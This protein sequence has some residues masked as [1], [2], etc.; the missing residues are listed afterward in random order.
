MPSI[1]KK[2]KNYEITI[3]NGYDSSGRKITVS[4]TFTPKDT[5]NEER[6]K[7]EVEKFAIRLEEKV[8]N[9][10]NVK[11]DNITLEK[12]S[13]LFL[14]D[15]KPPEVE[16]TTYYDY[17]RR[18]QM[19]IIPILGREKI[20][21]ING[22]TI[23]E[24]SSQLRKDGIRL[25]GKSGGL[26]EGSINKDKAV[27]SSLLSY[28]VYEGLLSINPLI[29]SGKRRGRQKASK[30]YTVDYFT[31]DQT[32]WFLWALENEIEIKH[33]AHECK[34]KDGSKYMVKEYTQKWKLP[35]KWRVFFMLSLFTGERRGEVISLTWEDLD[36]E[37]GEVNTEISTVCVEGKVYHKDTKTHAS[38]CPVVPLFVMEAAAELLKEQKKESLQ[39]GDQWVG[40][41]GSKF[42]KNFVFTQWNGQQMNL[43]SPRHEFKRLIRIYNDN[44]AK[45]EEDLLP[46]T[47]TLHD[48]RHTAASILISNGLDVQSVAGVLGHADPTTTLNIYSY[49]F[50][51][52]NKEAANIMENVLRPSP[53]NQNEQVI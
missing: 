47:V 52:K 34:R 42:K 18:L 6:T 48:L 51:S 20:T 44:V 41:K 21:N 38:R 26:S 35:I 49:F 3:S 5:W 1:R 11:A 30:E 14:E 8:K 16:R 10:Y 4:R 46:E 32:K 29:Y 37:T 53:Q 19:R 43:G 33:K 9:G 7:K 39:L 17:T 13:V 2:G 50:R 40:Y 23:K 22:H 24:Y 27:I 12:L 31:I 28:A 45:S 36:F 15:V 25:D